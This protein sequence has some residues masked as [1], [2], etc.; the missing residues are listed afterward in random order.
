MIAIV[1][2]TPFKTDVTT[3]VT[4]IA[5]VILESRRIFKYTQNSGEAADVFD[6][7][8]EEFIL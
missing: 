8:K 5:V 1:A 3:A 7:I 2:V 4:V 6:N